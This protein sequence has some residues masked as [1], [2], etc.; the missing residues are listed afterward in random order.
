MGFDHSRVSASLSISVRNEYISWKIAGDGVKSCESGD[1]FPPNPRRTFQ[2]SFLH[3]PST[4]K[5]HTMHLAVPGLTYR[6]QTST[7]V[8]D[9]RV[10]LAASFPRHHLAIADQ[11]FARH[12]TRRSSTTSHSGFKQCRKQESKLTPVIMRG[13][14][15][16]ALL[17]DLQAQFRAQL[18]IYHAVDYMIAV[19][20]LSKL[21]CSQSNSTLK[22][23]KIQ[24]SATSACRLLFTRLRS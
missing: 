20:P 18:S 4:S 13:L 21:M 9:H 16:E 14:G 3:S 23:K 6:L 15:F 1:F 8:T 22:T 17:D 11:S 24:C 10:R 7:S 5:A 12:K 19:A 2:L